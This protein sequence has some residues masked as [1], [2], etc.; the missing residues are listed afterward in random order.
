MYNVI[1]SEIH[2]KNL[3][4]NTDLFEIQLVAFADEIGQI[5]HDFEDGLISGIY[6]IKDIIKTKE[7][8]PIIG[9]CISAVE[10]RGIVSAINNNWSDLSKFDTSDEMQKDLLIARLRSE[11]IFMLTNDSINVAEMALNKFEDKHPTP[12]KLNEY[13]LADQELPVIFHLESC[14]NDY[15]RLKVKL[16]DLIVKSERVSRMDGKADYIL[17]NILEV[18]LSKPLQCPQPLLDRYAERKAMVGSY[19]RKGYNDEDWGKL[20]S[21]ADFVRACV[22]FVGGMTDRY[23]L[24][25]FDQ[26][27]SAYPR[28]EL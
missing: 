9:R 2:P 3:G 23:A 24:M 5:L 6:D 20:K 27:Y 22:D 17:R 28:R 25:E 13:I 4:A 21:D 26:L 16:K 14:K 12:A 18:Y 15:A 7:E 11:I 10:S 19:M 1:S 8:W